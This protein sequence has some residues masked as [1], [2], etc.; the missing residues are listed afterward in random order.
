MKNLKWVILS[1]LV[2]VGLVLSWQYMTECQPLLK[3]KKNTE[4]RTCALKALDKAYG[5]KN[6]YCTDSDGVDYFTKGVVKTDIHPEGIEDHLETFSNGKIYLLEGGCSKDNVYMYYQKNCAELNVGGKV[7]VAKDGACVDQTPQSLVSC[8]SFGGKWDTL[9]DSEYEYKYD[10]KYGADRASLE[11]VTKDDIVNLM[12]IIDAKAYSKYCYTQ[13]ALNPK[14][15]KLNA[16][17]LC[18]SPL[19]KLLS[20]PDVD[21]LFTDE[22]N[23]AICDIGKALPAGPTPFWGTKKFLFD[24][25]GLSPDTALDLNG[26]YVGG[27]AIYKNRHETEDVG[28]GAGEEN[29]TTTFFMNAFDMFEEKITQRFRVTIKGQK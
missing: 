18:N 23:Y 11:K 4:Y 17:R 26:K 15:E 2:V 19:Y 29:V 12:K 25:V 6:A 13:E 10:A 7:Y 22:T 16:A 27:P 21:G 1:V 3:A 14:N 5:S 8:D 9:I 20:N 28:L 24:R